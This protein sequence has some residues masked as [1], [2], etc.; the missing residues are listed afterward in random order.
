MGKPDDGVVAIALGHGAAVVTFKASEHGRAP[1]TGR[2]LW[3]A[4][5]GPARVVARVGP[6]FGV[7][8]ASPVFRTGSAG[9]GRPGADA[10]TSLKPARAV[11][12]AVP[13]KASACDLGK[14]LAGRVLVWA[15]LLLA[16]VGLS[17]SAGANGF[18]LPVQDAL[19]VGRANAGT[20]AAASDASTVFHN[21]AGMTELEASRCL[22]G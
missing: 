18:S 20:V 7:L 14:A 21:P 3:G 13:G 16:G 1:L 10:R 9:A 12:G 4:G 6:G 22:P 15:P 5:T 19:Q 11:A 17:G 8:A 2:G